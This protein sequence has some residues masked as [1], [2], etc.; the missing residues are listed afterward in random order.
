MEKC[1]IIKPYN[2]A[3]EMKKKMTTQEDY[4]C[5]IEKAVAY[6][7]ENI[8]EEIDIA[9]LAH[10]SAFSTFHFHRIVKAYLGVN[11]GEFIVR[12]RLEKAASLLRYSDISISNLA[13]EIGY[14]T[15]SSFT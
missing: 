3:R 14:A 13:C 1:I 7:R 10:I 2:F 4:K 8:K 9:T 6:V 11:V 15:P 5:R 12:E